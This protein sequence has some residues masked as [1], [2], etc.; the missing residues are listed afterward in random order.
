MIL[1]IFI[2]LFLISYL[3][4]TRALPKEY[5]STAIFE[6]NGAIPQSSYSLMTNRLKADAIFESVAENL[7]AEG[8]KKLVHENGKPITSSEISRGLSFSSF[9]S[10]M[11]SFTISF[12]SNDST[13]VQGVLT[14]YT[15]VALEA[16]HEAYPNLQLSREASKETK[17][18]NEN[19]YFLIGAAASLVLALG[20]P[21]VYEI[22]ADQVFDD[23]DIKAFGLEGFELRA[24]GR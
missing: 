7:A 3:V 19:R 2:P 6:Y 20:I 10:N 15:F 13:I 9:T 22:I 1:L 17:T 4:P 5:T 21:F 12:K 16:I 14:E 8:E 23:K 18:S 11:V 24:S